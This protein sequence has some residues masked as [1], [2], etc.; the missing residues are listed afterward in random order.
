MSAVS[1]GLGMATGL[2]RAIAGGVQ[3]RKGEK[4]L[5]QVEANR[6]IYERPEEAYDANRIS[7]LRYLNPDMPGQSRA[8]DAIKQ[9][10]ASTVE[11]AKEFGGPQDVYKAQVNENVATNTLAVQSAQSRI[12]NEIQRIQQLGV[13]AD[14]SDKEF[15][16]NEYI[17]FQENR[18]RALDRIGAGMKN[19]GSGLDTIAQ[20]SSGFVAP[21]DTNVP[22]DGDTFGKWLKN[23]QNMERVGNL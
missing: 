20:V 12:N 3:K 7:A 10:T 18:K 8:M 5:A 19:V 22:E 2:F 1:G 9:N 15:D 14:Y 13:M 23:R 21:K 4:E 17:P 6:P 11:A 16:T